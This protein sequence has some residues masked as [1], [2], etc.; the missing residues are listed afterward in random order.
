[1]KAARLVMGSMFRIRGLRP[2]N[3]VWRAETRSSPADA[4]A[5]YFD[6][7]CTETRHCLVSTEGLECELFEEILRVWSRGLRSMPPLLKPD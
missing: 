3:C 2:D 5:G 7:L 1:M 4:G 6:A